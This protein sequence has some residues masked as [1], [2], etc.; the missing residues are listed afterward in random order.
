MP[1]KLH[2]QCTG[3][4]LSS[5]T[6]MLVHMVNEYSPLCEISCVCLKQTLEDSH[7]GESVTNEE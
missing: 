3:V 4:V 2:F 5:V 6:D 1:S 7:R